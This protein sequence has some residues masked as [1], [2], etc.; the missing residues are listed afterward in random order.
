MYKYRAMLTYII[1]H[2]SEQY[3][4]VCILMSGLSTREKIKKKK[5]QKQQKY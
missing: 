5:A 4:C 3:V 2:K 1:Y